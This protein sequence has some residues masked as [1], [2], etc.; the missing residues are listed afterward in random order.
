MTSITMR[1]M[2]EAGVHFGHQKRFWNPKMAPYIFGI[3]HQIHIINLE[4]TL[5]LYKDALNFLGD[6]AAKKGKVLFVGTKRG[7]QAIIRE[8]A[9]RCGMPYVDQRWLGGMLTNYKTIRQSI[10]RL[11][12]LETMTADGSFM[13]LTKK[14]A[15]MQTRELAKLQSGLNGI[16][17]MGGL[18]DAL[19]IIDI[20]HEKTALTE[21][22]K[23]G[24]PVVGVVD[25]NYNPQLVDYVVPGNDDSQRAIRLYCQGL[26]DAILDARQ[27]IVEQVMIQTVKEPEHADRAKT[28]AKKMSRDKVSSAAGA[29]ATEKPVVEKKAA[30]PQAKKVEAASTDKAPAAKKTTALKHK[31]TA[32]AVVNKKEKT[33]KDEA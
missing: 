26:A 21:A 18:P 15:L 25:T 7:A 32:T 8:E 4:H 5:P 10:R 30:V 19:F 17:D 31:A 1:Q 24:I 11:K 6:I 23:L 27:H 14:E 12:E 16:K 29:T 9:T 2:L 22:K 3:R 28:P 20:G 33:D 13:R